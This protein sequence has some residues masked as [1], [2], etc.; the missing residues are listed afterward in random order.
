MID[1]QQLHPKPTAL[2][3]QDPHAPGVVLEPFAGDG[4]LA[5]PLVAGA[6]DTAD[7]ARSAKPEPGRRGCVD[8]QEEAPRDEA[9]DAQEKAAYDEPQEVKSQGAAALACILEGYR[10]EGPSE[11][12][13]EGGEGSYIY[14]HGG[15]DC[16]RFSRK[17]KAGPRGVR[18]AFT[19]AFAASSSSRATRIP[20]AA[21]CRGHGTHALPSAHS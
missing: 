12:G 13:P 9:V 16:I 21:F 10:G 19:A 1:V 2:G 3:L 17:K 6:E 8:G 11:S 18:T 14:Y 20:N 7:Q 4:P 15:R 5:P